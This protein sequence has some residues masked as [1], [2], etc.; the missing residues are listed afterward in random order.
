MTQTMEG[1]MCVYCHATGRIVVEWRDE[2]V[3]RPNGT[4]SLA[5]MGEKVSA[6]LT[7]WPWAVCKGCGHASRGKK[8][9]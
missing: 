6:V 2:Y 4:Y 3:P 5:G 1:V 7:R 9:S 8:E